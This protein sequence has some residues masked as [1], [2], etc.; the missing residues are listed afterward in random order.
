MWQ[1]ISQE[2]PH[3]RQNYWYCQ[4]ISGS[5]QM[6]TND[7]S[8]SWL[9]IRRAS[10]LYFGVHWHVSIPVHIPTSHEKLGWMSVK[11]VSYNGCLCHLPYRLQ[12]FVLCW[13]L[14]MA[15]SSCQNGWVHSC[16]FPCATSGPQGPFLHSTLGIFSH[17]ETLS[18]LDI[19]QILAHQPVPQTNHCL[20][21]MSD[22]LNL[23]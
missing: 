19:C 22:N 11:T 15:H 3:L 18:I 20:H 13:N 21:H 14:C 1:F 6:F 16:G 8:S 10:M 4:T 5:I 23:H 7:A 2:N 9:C 12:V 17:L